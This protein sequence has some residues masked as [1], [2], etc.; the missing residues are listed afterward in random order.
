VFTVVWFIIMPNQ[1]ILLHYFSTWIFT[2]D[3]KIT[4]SHNWLWDCFK[5]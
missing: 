1:S 4:T 2:I 3:Y 5:L